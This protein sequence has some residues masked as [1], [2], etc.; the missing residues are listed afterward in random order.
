MQKNCDRRTVVCTGWFPCEA[1]PVRNIA[2]SDPLAGMCDRMR[3]IAY[4]I[5]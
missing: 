1:T 4:R 2:R 3:A 5:K